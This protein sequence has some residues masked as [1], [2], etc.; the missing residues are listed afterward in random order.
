LLVSDGGRQYDDVVAKKAVPKAVSRN[1]SETGP[2]RGVGRIQSSLI[3]WD[4]VLTGLVFNG[5]LR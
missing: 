5:L 1:F 4:D 2:K 3:M